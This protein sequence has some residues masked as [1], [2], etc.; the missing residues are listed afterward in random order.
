M[1]GAGPGSWPAP[2]PLGPSAWVGCACVCF[3]CGCESFRKQPSRAGRALPWECVLPTA[4]GFYSLGG[5][6][7]ASECPALCSYGQLGGPSCVMW[8]GSCGSPGVEWSSRAQKHPPNSSLAPQLGCRCANCR[9]NDQNPLQ[10][11]FLCFHCMPFMM[12]SAKDKCRRGWLR[13]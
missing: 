3:C 10:C 6:I 13:A 12:I 9:F 5:R 11:V 2:V 7:L 1:L 4:G 8:A